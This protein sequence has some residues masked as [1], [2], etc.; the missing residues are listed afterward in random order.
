MLRLSRLFILSF[1]FLSQTAFSNSLDHSLWGSLLQKHVSP[2][3]DGISTVV[4]YQGL[5]QDHKK[6]KQYLDRLSQTS[7]SEF[8]R[9]P[10][11]DQLAFL[12]NAYNAWTVE[13]ILTEWPNLTSIKD[14][15]SFFSSPWSKEFIPLLGETRTLDNIEHG[16]IRGSGLYNDPRIHFAVNC[17]ST[18]CPALRA[19][20]Y[21]G[22]KLDQ[23][24]DEQTALFLSDRS[25][26]HVENNTI[27]LSPIFKWYREDFEKGWQGYSRLEDFLSVYADELGISKSVAKDLKTNDA[28]IEFLNYD[29]QL[30]K[31]T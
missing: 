10:K 14:L 11:D 23:Q 25:R 17:A 22:I 5:A 12:I 27:K 26:N 7:R 4:D 19:E 31:K 13:L 18:G 28:D 8:E 15:G 24:L 9:W 1:I 3:N 20:A 2:I 29:W 30:N 16:L 21:E 6:L